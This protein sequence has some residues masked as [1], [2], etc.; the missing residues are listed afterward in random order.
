MSAIT[1]V[2]PLPGI[3][4]AC[5]GENHST[6]YQFLIA[7]LKI[8]DG[9]RNLPPADPSQYPD[10][11][12]R[13]EA[14]YDVSKA[15]LDNMYQAIAD[16]ANTKQNF[17]RPAGS[18]ITPKAFYAAFIPYMRVNFTNQDAVFKAGE[19]IL[20]NIMIRPFAAG[21]P[22]DQAFNDYNTY[23]INTKKITTKLAY[24]QNYFFHST[25][26]P[27]DSNQKAS[28]SSFSFGDLDFSQ[29]KYSSSY[30]FS[31]LTE[32]LSQQL[33]NQL[34][35]TPNKKPPIVWEY[36]DQCQFKNIPQT[37]NKSPTNLATLLQTINPTKASSVWFY[38]D[39]QHGFLGLSNNY[40]Y[41]I[42][43]INA[44]KLK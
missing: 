30:L 42:Q 29:L 3:V 4:T 9:T 2:A 17:P 41:P 44:N 13:T 12:H 24:T 27:K 25:V 10:W 5:Q 33:E 26:A 38:C 31:T 32:S 39:L 16:T 14:Q 34:E 15:F 18:K 1:A 22:S 35:K 28:F 11:Y 40:L 7:G 23:L 19:K 8:T 6:N 43:I 20:F 37:I 21:S 36:Y